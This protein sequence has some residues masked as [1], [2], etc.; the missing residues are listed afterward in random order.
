MFTF[1]VNVISTAQVIPAESR[2]GLTYITFTVNPTQRSETHGVKLLPPWELGEDHAPGAIDVSLAGIKNQSKNIIPW[3]KYWDTLDSKY[4]GFN[5][6]AAELLGV[7]ER[8]LHTHNG[9]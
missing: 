2:P 3:L 6:D 7:S 5:Y 9:K 8:L 1:G 4:N